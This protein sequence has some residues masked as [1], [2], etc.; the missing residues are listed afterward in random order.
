MEVDRYALAFSRYN[1]LGGELDREKFEELTDIF[2][3][4]C[5]PEGMYTWN[6]TVPN[7]N[8]FIRDASIS[9]IDAERIYHC[10]DKFL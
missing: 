3:D 1:E 4:I 9:R 6:T 2:M 10:V 8:K 7:F 5:A